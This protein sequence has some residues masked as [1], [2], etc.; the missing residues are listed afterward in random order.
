MHVGIFGNN[1]EETFIAVS[2]CDA[3][4]SPPDSEKY[5][6]INDETFES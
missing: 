4:Y 3:T 1:V 2:L 5:I 6:K